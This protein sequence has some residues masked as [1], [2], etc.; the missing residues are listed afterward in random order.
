MKQT[1]RQSAARHGLRRHPQARAQARRQQLIEAARALLGMHQVDSLSLPA[2][3]RQA[4]IAPS[5]TYHFFTDLDELF[6]EVAITIAAEMVGLVP[7][8]LKPDSWE[9][10]V[11]AYLECAMNFF[12]ADPAALQLILGEQTT[13]SI[14]RAACREGAPFGEE[15][16]Q[17]IS[18]YFVLPEIPDIEGVFFRAIQIAD[19]MFCLSVAD[20]GR[21]TPAM[22]E[23][24]LRAACAYLS[25]YLPRHLPAPQMLPAEQLLK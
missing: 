5:S 24:S 10:V 17:T 2:V 23:E 3:A 15:L 8:S 16:R 12:N 18:Q 22:F 13:S 25:V 6:R 7:G 11:R 9:D 21:I 1:N 19:L 20:H 14:K 4:G